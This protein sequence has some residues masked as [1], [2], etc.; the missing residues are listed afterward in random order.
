MDK[1]IAFC[2]LICSE[3][4]VYIATNTGDSIED[5]TRLLNS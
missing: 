1:I 3:C 4:P 5:L 2:G